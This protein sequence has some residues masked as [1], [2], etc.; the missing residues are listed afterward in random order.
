MHRNMILRGVVW[1]IANG[2]LCP[3]Y[4]VPIFMLF[5]LLRIPTAILLP[6][7]FY[8]GTTDSLDGYVAGSV[9]KLQAGQVY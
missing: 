3:H 7:V 4:F 9:R 5:V 1:V 8:R 6:P 2:G